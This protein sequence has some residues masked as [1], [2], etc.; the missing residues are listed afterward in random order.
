MKKMH[1]YGNWAKVDVDI[2]SVTS[3]DYLQHCEVLMGGHEF[4]PSLCELHEEIA[5]SSDFCK[6]KRHSAPWGGVFRIRN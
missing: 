5:V 2:D 4:F 6:W 1:V 3:V